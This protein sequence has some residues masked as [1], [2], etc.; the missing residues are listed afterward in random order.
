MKDSTSL[1]RIPPPSEG[2]PPPCEGFHLLVKEW[3]L[4]RNF[5]ELWSSGKNVEMNGDSMWSQFDPVSTWMG[6]LIRRLTEGID[7]SSF[8]FLNFFSG[9]IEYIYSFTSKTFHLLVKDCLL[10][11]KDSQFL[12]KDRLPPPCEG[13]HLLVKD[14]PPSE[15]LPPP[16]EG[17]HLLV[18]D[19]R[20]P[21]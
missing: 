15:G 20:P 19:S 21:C 5:V 12:V 3:L 9:F 17:F 7:V 6:D 11:V 14:S 4:W 10:L 1:W 16:C 13:F 18:K 8:L 2:L